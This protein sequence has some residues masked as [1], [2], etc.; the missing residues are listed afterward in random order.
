MSGTT[1][2]EQNDGVRTHTEPVS[3]KTSAI[4][5]PGHLGEPMV[6]AT[7]LRPSQSRIRSHTPRLPSQKWSRV[8]GSD[9]VRL[10]GSQ[11]HRLQCEPAKSSWRKTAPLAPNT[12]PGVQDQLP[13]IYETFPGND[14][15]AVK[16]C[17]RIHLSGQLF[18]TGGCGRICTC[19]ARRLRFYKPTRL[20]RFGAH[21]EIGSGS[22]N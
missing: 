21:P 13:A 9:P 14:C 2:R 22:G 6:F 7:T 20:S 1:G 19:S 16:T 3:K 15:G 18:Q 8:S 11:F 12:H 4:G 17:M 10:V 5:L